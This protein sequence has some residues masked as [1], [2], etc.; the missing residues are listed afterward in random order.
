MNDMELSGVQPS[1]L[2]SEVGDRGASQD[3]EAGRRTFLK[4]LGTL[5]AALSGGAL[6]APSAGAQATSQISKGDAA[7]LRFAAAAEIIES[8][9]WLQYAELGGV[10]DDEVARLASTLI[11]GYPP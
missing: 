2:K 8:D 3:R 9:L 4:G 1:Q 11:P 6:M 5:G 10:Q 7:L